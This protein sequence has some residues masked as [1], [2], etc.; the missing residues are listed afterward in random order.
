MAAGV[1]SA[2]LE[3]GET[4]GITVCVGLNEWVGESL[5]MHGWLRIGMK[6]GVV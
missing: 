1:E 2:Q 4:R 3:S 5:K 6:V